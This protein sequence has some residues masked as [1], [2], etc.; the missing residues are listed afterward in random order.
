MTN[1]MLTVFTKDGYFYLLRRYLETLYA[2]CEAREVY[3]QLI[4]KLLELHR[5]NES[6]IKVNNNLPGVRGRAPFD[7]SKYSVCR[8][9]CSFLHVCTNLSNDDYTLVEAIPRLSHKKSQSTARNT[10]D[11]DKTYLGKLLICIPFPWNHY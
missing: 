10:V 3:L 2:G 8:Y 9:F 4:G 7:F 1:P 11:T 6:H 5:L